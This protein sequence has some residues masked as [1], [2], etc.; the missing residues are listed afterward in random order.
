MSEFESLFPASKKEV[1]Q[2]NEKLAASKDEIT[3]QLL[4]EQQTIAALAQRVDQLTPVRA[5]FM[6]RLMLARGIP[7]QR[8]WVSYSC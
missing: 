1:L 3:Q 7:L 5:H 4:I 2:I 8:A 6:M